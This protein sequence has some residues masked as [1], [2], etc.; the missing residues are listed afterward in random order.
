MGIFVNYTYRLSQEECARLGES[1][2]YVKVYQC[3]RKHLYTKLNGYGDNG[4][5][6][7]RSSCGSTYCT[8]SA[9]ALRVHHNA[10][11]GKLNQY[12]NTAGYSYAM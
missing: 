9:D 1:V 8:C 3:N 4:Q 12:F 11:S 2:P 6:K 7:M 10:Q 5:R